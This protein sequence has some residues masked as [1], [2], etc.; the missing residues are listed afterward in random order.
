MRFPTRQADMALA[1]ACTALGLG[2]CASV[3]HGQMVEGD[4]LA[5]TPVST[6]RL[7]AYGSLWLSEQEWAEFLAR[8]D[9]EVQNDILNEATLNIISLYRPFAES[10]YFCRSFIVET[11]TGLTSGFPSIGG[12][13]LRSRAVARAIGGDEDSRNCHRY[14]DISEYF[15]I[16]PYH[17]PDDFLKEFLSGAHDE[18][19]RAGVQTSH[20]KEWCPAFDSSVMPPGSLM[21]E[22][23]FSVPGAEIWYE[24]PCDDGWFVVRFVQAASKYSFSE[25]VEVLR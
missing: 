14:V 8:H 18:L 23:K 13:E 1:L 4:V 3:G 15:I 11:Y 22:V 20:I 17:V 24:H 5:Q 25:I 16:E 21:S 19:E 2:G 9:A 12:Y 6:E 7:I 10:A